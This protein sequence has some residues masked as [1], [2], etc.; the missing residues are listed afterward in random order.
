MRTPIAIFC[1]DLHLS[2]TA[3]IW[4]S[5]EPD[6]YKAQLRAIYQLRE[7]ALTYSCPFIF[8]AGDLFDRWNSPPELINWA[9][10]NLPKMYAIPGQH[11]L[12]NHN[13][14]EIQKSAFWTLVE[15]GKIYPVPTEGIHITSDVVAH[16]FQF[17][18]KV[19]PDKCPYDNNI[20]VVHEYNWI[21]G[22]SYPGASKEQRVSIRR[23]EFKGYD[24][25]F[26]GD[27]HIPF[28]YKMDHG[29]FWNCG[30]LIRRHANEI[31]IKPRVL[32]LYLDG[33]VESKKLDTSEDKYLPNMKEYDE[34]EDIDINDL[35]EQFNQLGDAKYD[36]KMAIMQYLEKKGI[37]ESVR[38]IL[39]K[40][41]E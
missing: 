41:M 5:C 30:C 36:F 25:V 20:A 29:A 16:G 23:K 10:A 8:C 2:H 35:I 40:A 22:A 24:L 19:K 7:I 6:W 12:P 1:S 9:I 18:Q 26:C 27:N 3:P 28:S 33:T 37:K 31:S 34:G 39:I 14:N 21:Q 15:A 13:P 11:D 17:G 4:R 38:N 32:I